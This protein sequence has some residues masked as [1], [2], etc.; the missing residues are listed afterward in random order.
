M[1]RSAAKAAQSAAP[2]DAMTHP[3]AAGEVH[4]VSLWEI[5]KRV[6][7]PLASLKLTVILFA[8]S[9]FLVFAGTLVQVDH[10]IWT[11]VDT[12]FRTAFA[13]I[14]F[15]IFFPRSWDVPGGF[16]FPGGWLI[17][18]LLLVNILAAHTVR[19]TIK[20]RG[21]RL[22][23]GLLVL[24]LGVTLTG[25]VLAG[26][27][28]QDVATTNNAAFWRVAIRLIKGGVAA[29]VLMVACIMLF[30]KRAGIVLLHGG[31]IL[32]LLSELIT[33]LF[34]VEGQMRIEEGHTVNYVYH[35]RSFEL[36]VIR[37]EDETTDD[38]HAIPQKML[39]SG[40]DIVVDDLPFDIE[41]DQWM[42][43]SHIDKVGAHGDE[44][45]PATAGSGLE[46]VAHPD[47][48]VSGTNPDQNIDIASAYITVKDRKTGQPVGKYLVSGWLSFQDIPQ[49][50]DFGDQHYDL[51]LRFARTYKPY[52]VYLVDFN[53]ETYIGTNTPKDFSSVV[54]LMDSTRGVDRQVKIW[55]NNPL[56]Y[57]GE[58]FYQSS[59]EPGDRVTILQVVKNAGWMVPYVACM[60]VGTG[61]AVHF[62]MNL[63]SFLRRRAKA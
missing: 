27:F 49:H 51:Y 12:Y 30:N 59:F 57:Q 39:T 19:F 35:T 40:H 21:T 2:V 52:S 3:T 9:V 22:W 43:N 53:H 56:R 37:H 60:I 10:G 6:L 7:E 18:G 62:G 28:Q 15:G 31:I 13:Y 24:V 16:Y 23:L 11:V 4:D 55:M 45:N 5:V 63:L 42:A 8:L 34:A 33:G 1:T 17:G 50:V 29:I 32:M 36:A 58:T 20:A 41:V 44:A 14:R 38:V 54:R 48:P 61:M 26:V 46:A 47:D 25:L